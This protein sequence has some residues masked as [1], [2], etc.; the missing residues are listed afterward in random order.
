[1]NGD[2]D[3]GMSPEEGARA[4]G[5][6]MGDVATATGETDFVGLGQV[7]D[8]ME[9][10]VEATGIE[11]PEFTEKL[12]L[13]RD[14]TSD[15]MMRF[16]ESDAALWTG[17][18]DRSKRLMEADGIPFPE[19]DDDGSV[20]DLYADIAKGVPGAV[21]AFLETEADP[22]LPSGASQHTALLAALDAPGRNVEDVALLI[23][24]GADPGEIHAEGDDALSWAMGYHHPGTVSAESEAEV[25]G[26]LARNGGDP[27][28]VVNDFW[29]T[30]HRAIIQA[31]APQVA[32]LLEAGADVTA[33][34][35][36]Q[37]HPEKLAHATPVM[38]AAPK[39][40]VVRVLLDHGADPR[41]PDA[42]GRAPLDFVREE[43]A[44]ARV[45]AEGGD[46][47]T[48]AHAEALGASQQ[49]LERY[50]TI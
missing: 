50:L 39:P 11:V 17:D 15:A 25:I 14:S 48:V 47:W 29:V 49:L 27:N 12:A 18:L 43:A 9:A 22:N 37:F 34:A 13:L 26:L 28:H 24:A 4:L 2:R 33:P 5:E 16:D 10:I 1:M 21:I 8:R 35:F 42:L 40:D 19:E 3:R 30:L 45:R 6:I 36:E 31:G 7:M 20:P 38:L 44:A 46:P 32:A 23:A 41:T